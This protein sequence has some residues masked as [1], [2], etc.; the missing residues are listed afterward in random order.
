MSVIEMIDVSEARDASDALPSSSVFCFPFAFDESA[1]G[2]RC[3]CVER[4]GGASSSD[5]ERQIGS[6]A[7]PGVSLLSRPNTAPRL[8]IAVRG[9]WGSGSHDRKEDKHEVEVRRK[10]GDSPNWLA[11][12]I[13]VARSA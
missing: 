4:G 2:R 6:S 13:G 3:G 7:L 10:V 12:R 11:T 9:Q 1:D 5:D 8:R